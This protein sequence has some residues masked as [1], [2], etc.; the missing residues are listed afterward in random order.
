VEQVDL[1]WVYF[2]M[3]KAHLHAKMQ[4]SMY[5]PASIKL[6]NAK[7]SWQVSLIQYIHAGATDP[8]NSMGYLYFIRQ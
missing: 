2:V 1:R 4:I 6:F 5:K 3:Q 8:S 7:I